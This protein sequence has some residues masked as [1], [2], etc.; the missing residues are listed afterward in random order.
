MLA[1]RN[2]PAI[3]Q[4]QNFSHAPQTE[5]ERHI[6]NQA[7]DIAAEPLD[8]PTD[9]IAAQLRLSN[10]HRVRDALADGEMYWQWRQSF[11]KLKD[12][13]I[14]LQEQHF[15]W[16]QACK[17]IKLYEVFAEFPFKQISWVDLQT[18][19]QLCQPRYRELLQQLRSLPTW[20]ESVVQELM[21]QWRD[22]HKKKR[23]Q[24][25]EIGTGWRQLPGGGRGYQLPMLHIDWLG[26]LIERA[27]KI[28]NST[29]SQ[30]IHDMTLFFV[31]S[32]L[33]PGLSLVG[34][35]TRSRSRQSRFNCDPCL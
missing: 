1:Q 31:N 25:E 24:T 34:V 10:H 22:E 2:C 4:S 3:A 7:T 15:T 32:G 33:V 6:E 14:C 8:I 26:V 18:L 23:P 20:T 35:R 21:Q 9:P 13:K 19:F 27:T 5:F 12:F 11:K 29:V 17:H 28:R 16:K 30:L